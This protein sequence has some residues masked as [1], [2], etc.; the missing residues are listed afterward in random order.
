MRMRVLLRF[1]PTLI[2]ALAGV[3]ALLAPAAAGAAPRTK[4]IRYHGYRLIVPAAWPVYHLGTQPR[5][6][7]ASS[8]TSRAA[9]DP[10]GPIHGG[11]PRP[12]CQAPRSPG[13]R[14][15]LHRARFRRLLDPEQ[16]GHVGLGRLAIPRRWDLHRRRER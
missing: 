8:R 7:P 12:G 10:R 16:L 2:L 14:P 6:D 9:L 3:L 4:V 13:R 15:D 11:S 1:R 5:S